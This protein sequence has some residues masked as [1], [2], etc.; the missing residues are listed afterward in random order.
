M[1]FHLADNRI[2]STEAIKHL[3]CY[4]PI[5]CRD[6]STQKHLEAVGIKTTFSGCLTMV[7]NLRDPRLGMS[8]TLD[9]SDTHVFVD[10]PVDLK[11][12]TLNYYVFI[13]QQ[14]RFNKDPAWIYHALQHT[15]NLLDAYA[16]TTSRLHIWLPLLCNKANVHL[17]NKKNQP[18]RVEDVDLLFPN[19]D[20]FQGL[21]GL[22]TEQREEIITELTA[23]C[24]TMIRTLLS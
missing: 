16:I 1:S 5:G 8:K 18:Y 22:S 2:L 11:A 13:T 24:H 14:G 4:E 17:V 10:V 12:D 3:K 21:V 23:N 19:N 20:R 6:I 15:Y 9:Y 7:I